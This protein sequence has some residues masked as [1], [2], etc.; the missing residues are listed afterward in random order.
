MFVTGSENLASSIEE[1]ANDIK[2]LV[3]S[4]LIGKLVNGMVPTVFVAQVSPIRYH[5]NWNYQKVGTEVGQN[6]SYDGHCI[7]CT[8]AWVYD[9]QGD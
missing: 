3:K 6:L 5:V 7:Q 9:S 8:A 2:S 1:Q 4:G